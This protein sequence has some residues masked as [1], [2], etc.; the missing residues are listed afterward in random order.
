MWISHVNNFH[1][2]GKF[3]VYS[4]LKIGLLPVQRMMPLNKAAIGVFT[5]K[6]QQIH[7]AELNV[8]LKVNKSTAN[9]T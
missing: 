4:H 6:D 1:M 7:T 9:R 8:G 2:Q 5:I 3:Q